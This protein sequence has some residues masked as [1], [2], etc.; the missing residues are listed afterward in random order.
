MAAYRRFIAYFYEYIDGKRQRNAGFVKAEQRGGNWRISLQ[1]KGKWWTEG[2]L[3]IYGYREENNRY[4]TV[5]L[6]KGYPQRDCLMRKIRLPEGWTDRWGRP[7][8]KLEGMWIPVGEKR[9]F[10]SHWGEGE[11]Q[12]WSVEECFAFDHAAARTPEAFLNPEKQNEKPE[13]SLDIQF[14]R[15]T[16]QLEAAECRMQESEASGDPEKAEVSEGTKQEETVGDMEEPEISEETKMTE[17]VVDMEKSESFAGRKESET[18]GGLKES[19][20][21][22]EAHQEGRSVGEMPE[23]TT[24]LHR[25][26]QECLEDMQKVLYCRDEKWKKEELSVDQ[27]RKGAIPGNEGKAVIP[28]NEE[29]TEVSGKEETVPT[30]EEMKEREKFTGEENP[31]WEMLC[32]RHPVIRPLQDQSFACVGICPGDVLWLKQR[33]WPVGRNSFLM[34]GFLAYRHLLLGK[35]EDG[36]CILG[37]PGIED[38]RM[39][40]KARSFGYG[41]FYKTGQ[42]DFGYWCRKIR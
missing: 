21:F 28:G 5:F 27:S 29:I 7:F 22:E 20:A 25:E 10:I 16:I 1:L 18:G 32:S 13:R 36:S 9:C 35:K 4:Q 31:V 2:E 6:A 33:G 19:E 15:N 3:E 30:Q 42:E 37:V 34:E 14:L 24:E 38:A 39:Q 26:P 8:E 11:P 17:A 40:K 41:E 23:N 12:P